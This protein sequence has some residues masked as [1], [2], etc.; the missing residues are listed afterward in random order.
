MA[1][2]VASEVD[3][4]VIGAGA[5]GVA[6]GRHLRS[7]RPDLSLQILEAGQRIGGR[8]RT[9]QVGSARVPVDLGC[10]W[11]HGGRDNAWM[12]IA[13]RTGFAI[14]QTRASWDGAGRH[15]GL[16]A[17][18]DAAASHA[19]GAFFA[20]ADETDT[21]AADLPLSACLEPGD[22]WN[23]LIEAIGTFVNGVELG[24]A[25]LRDYRRYDPGRGPD[26]RVRDGYGHLIASY[27]AGLPVALDAPATTIDHRGSSILVST[28]RGTLTA[29][30]VIVTVS[31]DVLA[32]EQVRFDPPLP[33]KTAAAAGLPLGLADK[34][35]LGIPDG[36]DLPVE[37]HVMGRA[38]SVRT[39]AYHVRPFGQPV[40][41]CYLGGSLA[42][43][44][45]REGAPAA[46]AF[47]QAELGQHLGADVASRLT[48]LCASAWR[49]TPW[50]NG[51]Y[52]YARPGAADARA[53]LAAPINNRLFFAGE[54]CSRH[55][56][57]TAHGAFE[58]GVASA[59][60]VAA[61]LPRATRGA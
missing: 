36:I 32:S 19:I 7:L 59:E 47:A 45:E 30:T 27:G 23:G 37:H 50:I 52:S 53:V 12:V 18:D 21:C 57:S 14:D 8:A 56:Y 54:A 61:A 13:A 35:F 40:I 20:R 24:R 10:G 34:L 29:R 4:A 55:R 44:L 5:A 33:D 48:L 49:R 11:L 51:S 42:E 60:A 25:S 22:Q 41:E 46:L 2:D 15:L 1:E 16:S 28:R 31:T 6:A 26:P 9:V 39:A 43:D 38:D 58:T 17:D 3:V